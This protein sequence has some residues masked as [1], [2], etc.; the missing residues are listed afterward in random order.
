[1]RNNY[2]SERTELNTSQDIK[3]SL[4]LNELN[5]AEFLNRM[6]ELKPE[7]GLV[8]YKQSYA[9][10]FI[11]TKGK[12]WE[13]K[14]TSQFYPRVTLEKYSQGG[15]QSDWLNRGTDY[16]AR[17]CKTTGWCYLFN[18][19]KLSRFIKESSALFILPSGSRGVIAPHQIH[20]TPGFLFAFNTNTGAVLYELPH[21]PVQPSMDKLLRCGKSAW[22]SLH[23]KV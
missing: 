20:T 12:T 22:K 7:L 21:G 13:L 18:G 11:D 23:S 8:K 1:M 2:Y 15:K 3:T 19:H 16:Y 6:K 10:D 9:Y 5:E 4:S 17:W 14:T